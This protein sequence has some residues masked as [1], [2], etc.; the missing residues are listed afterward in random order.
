MADESINQVQFQ[1]A[2]W[3]F[4]GDAGWHFAS[5]PEDLSTEIKEAFGTMARGWG[6]LP[7]EATIGDTMWKTSIFWDKKLNAYL[8]P[9]KAEVRKRERFA[10]GETIS[11]VLELQL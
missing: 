10:A 7:V 9:L 1:T 8:L 6:S 3:L 2:V 4:P 11:V 5:V